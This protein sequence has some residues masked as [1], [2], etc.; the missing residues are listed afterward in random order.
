MD[1]R[2]GIALG[3]AVAAKFIERAK[4]DGAEVAK[5]RMPIP[6]KPPLCSEMI[7]PLDPGMISPLLG[8]LQAIIVVSSFRRSVT[9]ARQVSAQTV[10]AQINAMGVVNETIQDGIS[11]C[12][13][14]YDAVPCRY[15][16]LAVMMAERR[17]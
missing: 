7:A 10:A 6:M 1:N 15:G 16:E 8:G 5:G 11:V 4:K 13:V 12:R 2:A 3:K 9:L 14:S 17:P